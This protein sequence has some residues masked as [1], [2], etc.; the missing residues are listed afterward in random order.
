MKKII[1]FLFI[2][3]FFAG[4]FSVADK[5]LAQD[6]QV[7]QKLIYS[8]TGDVQIAN[9]ENSQIFYDELKGKAR[10]YF[11]NS[12]SD[13]E[14]YLNI[15]V[16]EVAN[17]EG[18]YSVTIF[19]VT[20]DTTTQIAELDSD[21]YNWQEYFNSF[22]RDWYW[23]G[24]EFDKQLM[25]GKYKIEVYSDDNQGKYV[26]DVG[27]KE[28]LN[29]LSVLNVYWQIPLLK[30]TFLKTSVLQFFLTPF[31]IAGI[32]ILGAIII[33][34]TLINY[35]VALIREII[36]HNQ[37]KTLLLTSDGMR[38]KED[39]IKLLQ[40]PAYDVTVAFVSTAAKP[41]DNLEYLRKD[42]M[43]MRDELGFN[44]EEIDIE[45]K[46]EKEVMTLLE[47]K[48]IIYMEG[49]NTFYLLKA[50]RDCNFEKI[51]RKLMK[52]G[53]VY[54]G[55]SAGS[56]VAGRTIQTAEWLGDKNI[57]RLKKMKGLGLI[58]FDIFVHYQPQYAEIIKQKI[59]NPKKR[60]KKLKILT[61]G[62]ALLVQGKEIDLI[63]DGE[64]V[65]V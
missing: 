4:Y 60:A 38:M 1:K 50:M 6:M 32:G 64:E 15:M 27:K 48:D 11:I 53:K 10:D 23:K 55:A 39:I 26:L 65:I 13:F 19:S 28:S 63:G 44:V 42:W 61:D 36:K 2:S 58:P 16:P 21:T 25:A 49:G 52:S 30:A 18:R 47:A 37:A 54:I 5:V 46:S 24:P 12:G 51:I 40:K 34:I 22:S 7:V 56:I 45:G 41:Q 62:Q 35:L 20:G 57:V 33:I 31:G 17:I 29:Y 43:I 9:P 3:L 8:Q 14:L 59:K